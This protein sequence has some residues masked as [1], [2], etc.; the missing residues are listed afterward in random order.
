VSL[1]KRNHYLIPLIIFAAAI[2]LRFVYLQHLLKLPFFDNPIMDASYHDSWARE[3]LEGRFLRSEPFFRAPLYPHVLALT[4]AISR[5]S[6]L[7]PRIV[8]FVLGGATS[9]IVYV[10][11]RRFYG[12]MAGIIAGLLCAVYPVL[13]YFDGELLT[14]SLFTLLTML[15]ILL[16]EAAA[17]VR[18]F[19]LWFAGGLILGLAL[20]TRPTIGL[21]LPLVIVGALM[22]SRRRLAVIAVL[23]AG[24]VVPAV[25]VAVHNYAASG[26]FIPL[27]WQGGLNFYLGNNPAADGWSATGPEIRKDWWG[28]YKDMV[29]IPRAAMGREPN[30]GEVSAF[31]SQRGLDF[32][33]TQSSQWLRLM[34]KKIALFWS[35]M[36]FPN[37]QD[38]N[39]MR[40]Q[41]WTLKNPLVNFGTIAPLA[42]LGMLVTARRWRHLFFLYAFVLAY[43]AATVTF[44]VCARYR[45]PVV[46]ALCI[47][48][49]GAIVHIVRMTLKGDLLRLGPRILI[50]AAAAVL[51]NVNITG[52]SLPDLAQSLTQVGKAYIERGD[53]SRA[54]EYFNKAVEAN[55]AWGEAYE[56]L[57]LVRMKSGE[58]DAARQLLERA[59]E[60]LP[61]LASAHRSLAM[62]HLSCGDVAAA[63]ASIEEAIAH[64]PY[65]EDA[66]NILGSIE[67]TEGNL[68]NAIILFLE[69]LEI[70]P[71]N[72][73]A[74]ANLGSAYEKRGDLD[75]AVAAYTKAVELSGQDADLVSALASLYAK[76]GQ[77]EIARSL[78]EEFGSRLPEDT[79]LRYNQAVI[80]QN[81]GN[82]EQ[83]KSIYEAIL[84]VVPSHEGALVN[85]GV[86]YARQGKLREAR[87]L[88]LRALEVN[89]TNTN[90]RRNL[91]LL[92]KPDD[93]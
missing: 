35:S 46:P 90:A 13:V 93:Q 57:G 28:G 39:F 53:E 20:I 30:F 21:F 18:K 47:F 36:E 54:V 61:D 4:Y 41:S 60:I 52:E 3:I 24:M 56:Q 10:L 64:A 17:R 15:G 65:L 62:L 43:F 42:L 50:L 78:L 76:R 37:N 29:A 59:V 87:H 83:A 5:G 34:L 40:T 26:E 74:Y 25:P 12:L 82:T 70:N 1:S 77:H 49:A 14:E 33:R 48:A 80:L 9:V 79:N 71:G 66:R 84:Q 81:D 19:H 58:T 63:R 75:K 2:G 51:V 16:I 32:V 72:W 55:P 85:L 31:W 69:E 91:D 89:P 45:M 7:F 27:V 67:R 88:W 11:A 92:D 38:Y 86:I 22:V 8:Q 23:L 44:F 73:R 68:D 6:F